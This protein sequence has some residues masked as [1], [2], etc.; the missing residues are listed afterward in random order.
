MAGK[1]SPC[2]GQENHGP[3]RDRMTIRHPGAPATALQLQG[4]VQE[5][6]PG[7]GRQPARTYHTTT[8]TI[9]SPAS[10][11]HASGPPYPAGHD[12]AQSCQP[13][14][15]E[16]NDCLSRNRYETC[17]P[18]STTRRPRQLAAPAFY[19]GTALTGAKR[20]FTIVSFQELPRY[21]SWQTFPPYSCATGFS[22]AD[23]YFSG[24]SDTQGI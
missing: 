9:N 13:Q 12:A 3:G 7:P 18:D 16:G 6:H 4:S 1:N 21:P 24:I 10:G 2:A 22:R 11:A 5:S 19:A 14:T 17:A 8:V 15:S 20:T 23:A